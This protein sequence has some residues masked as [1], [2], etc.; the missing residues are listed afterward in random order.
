MAYQDASAAHDGPWT[1]EEEELLAA[2]VP[3]AQS[4]RVGDLQALHE[5]YRPTSLAGYTRG[6]QLRFEAMDREVK[7]RDGLFA[8]LMEI[9][10]TYTR[11]SGAF[12]P[13]RDQGRAMGPVADSASERRLR[14]MRDDLPALRAEYEM[15]MEASR[16]CNLTRETR[17]RVFNHLH[18]LR[19]MIRICDAG[20]PF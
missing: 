18:A 10:P 2:S 20:R 3:Q 6:D 7:R 16:T 17:T 8:A 19:N 12:V 14:R 9:L 5:A 11:G 15:V 13:L 1:P 4:A